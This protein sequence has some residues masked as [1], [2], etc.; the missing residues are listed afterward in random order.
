MVPGCEGSV[1]TLMASVLAVPVPQVLLADT[2]R[3][4]P[5]DPTVTVMELV[6]ELPVHPEGNVQEYDVAPLTAA[7]E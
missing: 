1:V 2:E 4:P 7:T 3:V 6:L 5:D